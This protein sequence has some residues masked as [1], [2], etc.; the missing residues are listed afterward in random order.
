MAIDVQTSCG[1]DFPCNASCSGR[2]CAE[3]HEDARL[4]VTDTLH[5][6]DIGE[7]RDVPMGQLSD[8][9]DLGMRN[10]DVASGFGSAGPPQA[11]LGVPSERSTGSV[12]AQDLCMHD[13]SSKTDH[14][15]VSHTSHTS[16]KQD[17][18]NQDQFS[19][20]AEQAVPAGPDQGTTS[21]TSARPA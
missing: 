7:A 16:T 2:A 9:T 15:C 18:N 6:G 11:D 14:L 3:I 20:L 4:S 1:T 5:N 8:S 19:R 10:C 13:V 21:V 17:Q 12:S